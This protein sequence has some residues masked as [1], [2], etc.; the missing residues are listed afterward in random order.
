MMIPAPQYF[1]SRTAAET[2]LNTEIEQDPIDYD[3]NLAVIQEVIAESD[4]NP[5][6]ITVAEGNCV[7]WPTSL[8]FSDG[9]VGNVCWPVA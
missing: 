9:Q 2:F 4:A 5:V 3:N 8:A 7:F 1:P 6:Y